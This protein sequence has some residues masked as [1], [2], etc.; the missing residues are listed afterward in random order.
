MTVEELRIGVN[1][2]KPIHAKPSY[3]AIIF[4]PL[5][6]VALKYGYNLVLH[7][8]LNRDMD[9][10]A[11]PWVEELGMVDNMINEFCEYVGGEVCLFN[12]KRNED[13]STAGDRFTQKPHGRITYVINI[14]RGGYLNGGGFHDLYIK[15]PE[16]YIDI[17]VIKSS[18][19]L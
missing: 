10:I 3:Y 9:L 15:D 13:G 5:K 14:F 11:I 7:G 17:S 16:T 6:K 1:K 2:T 4:E 8:S 19:E 18:I 12:C